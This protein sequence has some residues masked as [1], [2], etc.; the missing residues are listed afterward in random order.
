MKKNVWSFDI[1]V[2][3]VSDRTMSVEQLLH[4]F[5]AGRKSD[6]EL[7]FEIGAYAVQ[8]G[9]ITAK[10][11]YSRFLRTAHSL[12]MPPAERYEK[13]R[14]IL[15]ELLNR[16]DLPQKIG[17]QAATELAELYEDCLHR[18]VGALAW[19][20]YAQR[21]GVPVDEARM[22]ALLE[23]LENMDINH[24]GDN[25]EDA[26]RL[27]MELQYQDN[28]PRMTE[29]FLREAADRAWENM[30]AGKSDAKNLY[31]QACL[32]LGEFYETQLQRCPAHER[33]IYRRERDN[34]YAAARAN[35]F[36]AYASW[37]ENRR[38]S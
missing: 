30:S 11:E 21:L 15:L 14:R 33:K 20:L 1:P 28:A 8:S 16:L 3:G 34:M 7:A 4:A 37:R 23:K 25:P 24:L 38:I 17:A 31:G 26:L 13:A 18:P 22:D 27:G 10:L 5:R 36:P 2:S 6:P 32:A 29:L 19:S 12:K 9:S 35:G